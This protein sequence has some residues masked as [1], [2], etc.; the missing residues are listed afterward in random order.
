MLEKLTFTLL[1]VPQSLIAKYS[2]E[3]RF[4]PDEVAEVLEHLRLHALSKLEEREKF[5]K[6]GVATLHVKLAGQLP[7]EVEHHFL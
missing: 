2:E 3:L 1:A 4:S 5:R 7:A 6:Q